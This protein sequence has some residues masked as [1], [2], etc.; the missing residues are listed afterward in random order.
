LG[1]AGALKKKEPGQSAVA[2]S[3]HTKLCESFSCAGSIPETA[4]RIRP[5]RF[6]SSYRECGGPGLRPGQA[7]AVCAT[8]VLGT[9]VFAEEVKEKLL[10]CAR[11]GRVRDPSPHI[12][13]CDYRPRAR[14]RVMSSGCSLAPI[15]S[16]TAEV[17]ISQIRASGR[18]RFFHT[19][20]ISRDS[21]N[22]PKSFS[23][24]VTPSL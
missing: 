20:S 23:G 21:P 2:A 8:A 3:E 6:R 14:T 22:S 1:G 5:S 19:R 7:A 16:S 10:S 11:L 15:Q 9:A 12:R 4:I 24:S 17:T 13:R 18:S